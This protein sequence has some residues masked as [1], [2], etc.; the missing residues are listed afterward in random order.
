GMSVIE[1]G[2][3]GSHADIGGGNAEGDLSDISLVWMVEKARAAGLPMKDL[4]EA[5]RR[6]DAPFLH[7]RNF[8]LAGDRQVI[9]RDPQ[10][11]ILSSLPQRQ[12]RIAGM[13]WSGTQP[14]LAVAPWRQ[15]DA[16][17]K[18]SIVG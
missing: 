2:F 8:D 18:V 15:K 1:R 13:R 10:G 16:D 5:Y 4:P 11:K 12:A 6:V 7:D 3:I 14:F 17:G 9:A